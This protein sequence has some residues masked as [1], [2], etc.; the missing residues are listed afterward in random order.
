MATHDRGFGDGWFLKALDRLHFNEKALFQLI[1]LSIIQ[2][3]DPM[4]KKN[5]ILMKID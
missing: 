1:I 5:G 3:E 4:Y 2:G